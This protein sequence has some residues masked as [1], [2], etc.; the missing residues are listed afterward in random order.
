M[1]RRQLKRE[2]G[3]LVTSDTK[4]ARSRR[5]IDLPSPVV[6]S[7]KAHRVRQATER[8]ALGYA[9]VSSDSILALS[10]TIRNAIK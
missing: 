6:E 5:A 2:G 7:T 10:L 1:V 3:K 4:T 8:L 9:E